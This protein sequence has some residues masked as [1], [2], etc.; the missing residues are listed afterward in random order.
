[1]TAQRFSSAGFTEFL[2]LIVAVRRRTVSLPTA[3]AIVTDGEDRVRAGSFFTLCHNITVFDL[4][5]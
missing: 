1:M 4:D 5:L 3:S 2:A